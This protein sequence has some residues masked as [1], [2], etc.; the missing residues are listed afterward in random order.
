MP[1]PLDFLLACKYANSATTQKQTEPGQRSDLGFFV[2]QSTHNALMA[3]LPFFMVMPW[4]SRE[5][6]FTFGGA[7]RVG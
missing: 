1:L 6:V 7:L 3:A 5:T 4:T 2:P